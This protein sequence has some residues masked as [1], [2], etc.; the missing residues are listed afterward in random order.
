M[1]TAVKLQMIVCKSI[2]ITRIWKLNKW[3]ICEELDL[4]VEHSKDIKEKDKSM[5]EIDMSISN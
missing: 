5:D 3:Q 1:D 4:L 2:L